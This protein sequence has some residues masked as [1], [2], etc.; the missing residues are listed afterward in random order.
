[1]QSKQKTREKV[2]R[3]IFEWGVA[4]RRV[5]EKKQLRPW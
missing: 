5:W 1:M 4:A 3:V 2:G